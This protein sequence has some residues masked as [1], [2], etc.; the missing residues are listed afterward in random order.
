MAQNGGSSSIKSVVST[1][2]I[3][4]V[5]HAD[6]GDYTCIMRGNNNAELR[7]TINTSIAN[8]RQCITYIIVTGNSM[9]YRKHWPSVYYHRFIL[10]FE[11]PVFF[12]VSLLLYSGTLKVVVIL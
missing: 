7:G 11:A 9:A 6:G 8:L 5:E 10:C 1:L 12:T 4:S 2:T 3:M